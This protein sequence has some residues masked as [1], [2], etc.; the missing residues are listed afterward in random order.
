LAEF[1]IRLFPELTA[2]L[3][4]A[5][6]GFLA[7]YAITCEPAA[8]QPPLTL[9]AD[10]ELPGPDLASVDTRELHQLIHQRN[11]PSKTAR[12]I[13]VTADAVRL[14]LA[15]HPAPARRIQ[16]GQGSLAGP[17][18]RSAR[19][20]KPELEQL[21]LQERL[22]IRTIAARCKVSKPVIADLLRHYEIP[23]GCRP[24]PGVTPAWLRQEY[25]GNGRSFRDLAQEAGT[26]A[27]V[28]TRW[29]RRYGLPIRPRGG[30]RDRRKPQ[31]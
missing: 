8:W 29:A 4:A 28:L 2:A 13:G 30:P 9:A 1:T 15:E 24:P 10:L 19:I 5:G 20:S 6:R 18:T 23:V 12:A 11:S 7:R 27:G 21:Y 17:R 3:D 26:S 22:P 16:R 25:L 31:H 14:I